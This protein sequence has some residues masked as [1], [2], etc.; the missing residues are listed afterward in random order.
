[1]KLFL[2]MF[3]MA[4]LNMQMAAQSNLAVNSVIPPPQ[5]MNFLPTLEISINFNSAVDITSF[6]DT[7]FQVWG[8]WS[9]SS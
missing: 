2:L 6:N 1:M 4:A 3:T 5:S 8:R 9:G 7:T